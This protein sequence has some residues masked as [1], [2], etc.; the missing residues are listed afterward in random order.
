M[1][2]PRVQ[3]V[4]VWT[5]FGFLCFYHDDLELAND[6]FL[7]AQTLDPDHTMAWVGQALAATRNGHHADSR[8]L[9]EHAVSLSADVVSRRA[10]LRRVNANGYSKP[11]ADLEFS[12]REFNHFLSASHGHHAS[13]NDL[14]P[15]FFALGRYLKQRPDDASALHLFG[16]VCERIGLVDLAIEHTDRAISVLEAA[17]EETEDPVIE[18][19]FTIA[20]TTVARLRLAVCEY[21]DA[22]DSF[23]SALGLM[24]EGGED[25]VLQSQCLFGSGLANF[26]LGALDM[27]I[28]N[29]EEALVAAGDDLQIRGHVTVLL[30]QTLWATGTQEG[31]EAAKSQLLDWCV[32][33]H[34]FCRL[35]YL[36]SLIGRG[37]KKSITQDPENLM[38][39]NALAGM[40]ILT[41]D[42]SLIDA[43]LSELISLPLDLRHRRDPRRDFS[44]ILRQHH[45]GQVTQLPSD[46]YVRLAISDY[47]PGQRHGGAERS[48]EGRPRGTCTRKRQTRTGD[49]VAS[50]WRASSRASRYFPRV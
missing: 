25:R 6:A 13:P 2:H 29:F 37:R 23:Q 47:S 18:R 4:N 9:F 33:A 12:K 1:I 8:M 22:L 48:S 17:Y 19:Q 11:Q 5:S 36:Y 35:T 14:F 34:S 31:Q 30:S 50:G 7:K 45:L 15:A 20:N 44:Y 38:A 26:K 24:P 21:E 42:D 3:N 49:P 28:Q 27:A 40:G 16:I 32:I 46:L 43:A 39:I 10:Y 41:D